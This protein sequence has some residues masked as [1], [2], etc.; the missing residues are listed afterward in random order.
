MPNSL[1]GMCY[2]I[3]GIGDSNLGIDLKEGQTHQYM[4]TTLNYFLN[5]L[6]MDGC[7]ILE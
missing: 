3:D 2:T 6:L 1:C 7:T 5:S 4:K